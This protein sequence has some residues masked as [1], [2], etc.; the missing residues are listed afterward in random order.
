MYFQQRR[1]TLSKI[2]AITACVA[3]SI[4]IV[5]PYIYQIGL[6]KGKAAEITLGTPLEVLQKAITYL[7]TILPISVVVF[8]KRKE[9]LKILQNQRSSM[10][11]LIA[12]SITTGL[13]YIIVRAPVD[14]EY[15]YLI[16]SCICLAIASSICF[17]EVYLRNQIIS[18]LLISSFL[19]P[20]SDFMLSYIRTQRVTDNFLEKGAYLHHS[21]PK[22]DALYSWISSQTKVNDIFIDSYLTIPVFARRQLYVGLDTRTQKEDSVSKGYLNGWTMTAELILKDV[23]GYPPEKIYARQKVASSIYSDSSTA[24]GKETLSALNQI[25]RTND[26]YIVARDAVANNKLLKDANFGKVFNSGEIAV[27][28]LLKSATS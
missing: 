14:I 13:I 24:I 16:L 19:L 9:F 15:K 25:S 23:N 22:Q 11:I 26:V 21:D 2:V 17:R 8:W 7:L 18:F 3:F 28:K 6:G 12:M 10:L 5:S 27:Y 4:L 1:A 20:M